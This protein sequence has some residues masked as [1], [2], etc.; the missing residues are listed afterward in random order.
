[1]AL[2]FSSIP[3]Q[4]IIFAPKY[5]FNTEIM[6][7]AINLPGSAGN[8]SAKISGGQVVQTASDGL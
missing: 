3:L 4:R 5:E 6:F 7:V 8:L 1:M 2:F